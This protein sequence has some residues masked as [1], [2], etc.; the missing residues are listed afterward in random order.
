M[1]CKLGLRAASIRLE[2]PAQATQSS[3]GLSA[4]A[5]VTSTWGTPRLIDD[6]KVVIFDCIEFNEPFRFTDVYV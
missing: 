2:A 1:P 4:S 5:T 6:G 3:R